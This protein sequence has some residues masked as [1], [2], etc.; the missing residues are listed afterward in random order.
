MVCANIGDKIL[1][2]DDFR[3]GGKGGCFL[4]RTTGTGCDSRV[5]G[6]S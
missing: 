1:F 6:S 5:T 2:L 4:G 3:G